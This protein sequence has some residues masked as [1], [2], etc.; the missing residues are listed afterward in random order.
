MLEI[1]RL[2]KHPLPR[3]SLRIAN[4]VVGPPAGGQGL[5]KLPTEEFFA[6]VAADFL[7]VHMILELLELLRA[8]G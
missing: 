4:C 5:H 7:E 3:Q 6:N 8:T 2:V 1:V